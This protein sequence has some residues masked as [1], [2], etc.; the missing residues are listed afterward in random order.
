[1]KAG[2]LVTVKMGTG[3]YEHRNYIGEIGIALKSLRSPYRILVHIRGKT[4]AFLPTHLEVI[5]ESR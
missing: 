3:I 4:K 1:M 2:D 5:N